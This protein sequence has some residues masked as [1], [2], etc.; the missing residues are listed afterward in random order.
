MQHGIITFFIYYQDDGHR[1]W[2][3]IIDYKRYFIILQLI[4]DVVEE[5]IYNTVCDIDDCNL[6]IVPAFRN[7]HLIAAA[8]ED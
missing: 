7:S 6:V 8:S 2:R 3:L 5:N 1:Y 4:N